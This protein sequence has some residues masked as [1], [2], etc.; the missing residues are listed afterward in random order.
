LD[1]L[2]CR[3]V[4]TGVGWDISDDMVDRTEGRGA[5]II[6]GRSVCYFRGP[7][8]TYVLVEYHMVLTRNRNLLYSIRTI[9]TDGPILLLL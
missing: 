1:G 9:I 8:Q 5:V 6:E 7:T 2:R 3:K 4:E